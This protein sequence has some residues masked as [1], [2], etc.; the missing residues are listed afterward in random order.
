MAKFFMS[1]FTSC[2]ISSYRILPLSVSFQSKKNPTDE[3]TAIVQAL[4]K[5]TV[6]GRPDKNN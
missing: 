6:R 4:F 2:Q 3:V 5:A 1:I